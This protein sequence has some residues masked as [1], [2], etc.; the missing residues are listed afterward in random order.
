MTMEATK[1]WNEE[2]TK[3]HVTLS[4]R[5]EFLKD[6]HNSYFRLLTRLLVNLDNIFQTF[7]FGLK[8]GSQ[9]VNSSTSSWDK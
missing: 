7:D 4:T 3:T 6:H 2:I 9:L 8:V 1:C 5:G